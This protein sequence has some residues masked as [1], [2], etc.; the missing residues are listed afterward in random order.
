MKPHLYQ[1]VQVL[2]SETVALKRQ[3]SA[4]VAPEAQVFFLEKVCALHQ[5]A[6]DLS[7]L[8]N[9]IVDDPASVPGSSSSPVPEDDG[10]H[11][12]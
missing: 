9:A 5:V 10:G 6:L 4:S 1:M 11:G 2:R 8:L 3:I 7:F 12:E